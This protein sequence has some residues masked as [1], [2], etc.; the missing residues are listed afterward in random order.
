M[1]GAEGRDFNWWLPICGALAAVFLLLPTLI[2]GNDAGASFASIPLAAV[3]I[4]ILLA[5]ALTKVRRH[6]LAVAGM[7]CIFSA[8]AFSL[9][10]SSDYLR[11]TTRWLIHS[12]SYKM[13]VLNQPA[14]SDE[15]LKHVEW[16]GWGFPGAGNTTVYL[17]LDPSDRLEVAAKKHS[18]GK[19]NG[20]P[21]EVVQV[22]R[23]ESRW[24][25]VLFYTHTDWSH[26][27]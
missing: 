1:S 4:V 2:W 6:S 18:P 7:I 24:Y 10:R 17:V 23:L 26:C 22:H 12:Q 19:F 25:T 3:I 13:Q 20:I 5:I 11:T 15:S 14:P 8:L 16:D 27:A 9:Y 21:C